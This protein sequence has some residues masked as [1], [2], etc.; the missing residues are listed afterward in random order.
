[1][2]RR[3]G[4]RRRQPR[5]LE[6]SDRPAADK[7]HLDELEA[8]DW[9]DDDAP[10]P[11][12]TRLPEQLRVRSPGGGETTWALYEV[13]GALRRGL[14]KD[15]GLR[16]YSESKTVVYGFYGL[17][18][19]SVFVGE[20]VE[21]EFISADVNEYDAEPALDASLVESLGR[22]WAV[23]LQDRGMYFRHSH[24]FWAN[25]RTAIV[26]PRKQGIGRTA[27]G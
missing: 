25:R 8:D 9:G 23:T 16:A 26:T 6:I 7:A 22:R 2:S 24:Q 17:A 13:D 27:G 21:F 18:G 12:R 14:D 1:M 19:V 3:S 4:T 10:A 11:T 20:P 5:L 15:A